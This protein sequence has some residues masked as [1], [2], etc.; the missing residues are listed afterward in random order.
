MTREEAKQ[1]DLIYSEVPVGKLLRRLNQICKVAAQV[2]N[3]D[4]ATQAANLSDVVEAAM[5]FADLV[6][7]E[8][9]VEAVE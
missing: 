8:V 1:A 2:R 6:D 5:K 9:R 7:S 4:M 3:H